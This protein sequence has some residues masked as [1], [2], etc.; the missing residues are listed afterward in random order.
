MDGIIVVAL[1]FCP[2][3]LPD[4]LSPSPPLSLDWVLSTFYKVA[5]AVQYLHDMGLAHGDLKLDNIVL[6]GHG[7]P[8]L[9]DFGCCHTSRVESDHMKA[10]TLYYLAP[11][12]LTLTSFDTQK[13]D[14]WSLGVMLFAMTTRRL[15]MQIIGRS[16]DRFR[17][18]KSATERSMMDL[19]ESSSR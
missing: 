17:R 13:A 8:K 19:S 2:V 12:L 6:D 15:L 16:P 7:N 14:I 11:E 4:L 3:R 5:S 1:E 9:I 18:G 10:G